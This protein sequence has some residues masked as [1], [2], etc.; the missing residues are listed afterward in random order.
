MVR[1]RPPRGRKKNGVIEAGVP[2]PIARPARPGWPVSGLLDGPPGL[3]EGPARPEK[4]LNNR[5]PREAQA[6]NLQ[7]GRRARGRAGEERWPWPHAHWSA[8]PPAGNRGRRSYQGTTRSP[9]LKASRSQRPSD[10]KIACCCPAEM[11]R[12][13]QTCLRAIS[14]QSGPSARIST[15]AARRA[16]MREPRGSSS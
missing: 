13:A 15:L 16:R 10:A 11:A 12:A 6:P 9:P 1:T 2:R 7:T 14:S 8:K 4:S 5:N 3:L